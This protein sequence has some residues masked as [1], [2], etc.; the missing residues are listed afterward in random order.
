MIHCRLARRSAAAPL[1]PCGFQFPRVSALAVH[2]PREVVALVQIFEHGREDLWRLIWQSD[3]PGRGV[4]RLR[5][6]VEEVGKVGRSG[7]DIL[8]GGENSLLV[9]DEEGDDGADAAVSGDVLEMTDAMI[10]VDGG[11]EIDNKLTWLQM[12]RIQRWLY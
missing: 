10:A 6:V 4:A 9:A 7:Q 8:M 2:E 5:V 1:D 3:T 12:L 11:S